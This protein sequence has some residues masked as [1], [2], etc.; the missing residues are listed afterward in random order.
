MLVVHVGHDVEGLVCGDGHLQRRGRQRDRSTWSNRD[1]LCAANQT[2]TSGDLMGTCCA[3][4]VQSIAANTAG[5][6]RP[7]DW[8]RLL[9]RGVVKD[10]LAE[11][12]R[13]VG[14]GCDGTAGSDVN[15]GDVGGVEQHL[16]AETLV[17]YFARIEFSMRK[18]CVGNPKNHPSLLA[19]DG[20]AWRAQ[21]KP[22]PTGIT[23]IG[24]GGR[25]G[26]SVI[27][28]CL[29]AGSTPCRARSC[30]VPCSAELVP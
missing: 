27:N 9:C 19:G 24:G 15:G 6:R 17:G 2:E 11:H 7:N 28:T 26:C 29:Q 12:D 23:N 22:N 5:R 25:H 21:V 16:R 1:V 8:G 13:G 4:R 20:H 10:D 30:P 18:S 3:W 14:I